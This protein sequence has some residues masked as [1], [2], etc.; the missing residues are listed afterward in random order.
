MSKQQQIAHSAHSKASGLTF[1]TTGQASECRT[2]YRYDPFGNTISQSGG[3]ADANVYRFSSKEFHAA[4]GMY[5]YGGRFY[6]P[7]L[8][9]WVN[10][11]PIA[12]AG[13]LNLYRFVG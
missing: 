2:K 3:L 12:E 4:S 9:R 6:D 13:G 1:R 8:Q 10:R 5:C 11:D 7:G